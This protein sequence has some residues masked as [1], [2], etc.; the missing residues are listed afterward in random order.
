[1][2]IFISHP[3]FQEDITLGVIRDVVST[4]D[5]PISSTDLHQVDSSSLV[6]LTTTAAAADDSHKCF[7]MCFFFQE[8]KTWYSM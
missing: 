5:I 1:M 2:C 3:A 4:K 7:F 8:N 6:N